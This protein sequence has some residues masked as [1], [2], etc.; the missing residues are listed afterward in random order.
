MKKEYNKPLILITDID[1]AAN[2]AS[3]SGVEKNPNTWN[4]SNSEEVWA[5]FF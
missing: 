4:D 3:I 1:L 2:I 5:E